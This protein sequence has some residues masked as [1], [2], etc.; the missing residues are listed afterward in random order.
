M[1][2]FWEREARL[3]A[4]LEDHAGAERFFARAESWLPDHAGYV[5]N[6]ATAIMR[7]KTRMDPGR[8]DAEAIALLERAQ[9]MN[10]LS[11]RI[12][13][14]Q[15]N[16]YR[17]SAH[18][19]LAVEKISEAIELY[20]YDAGYRMDRAACYLN[21]RNWQKAEADLEFIEREKL[22]V[23]EFQRRDLNM[24][25]DRLQLWR[26]HPE[27]AAQYGSHMWSKYEPA[28]NAP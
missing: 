20:P 24:L 11:P 2:E 4:G 28:S 22:P 15:S 13:Q 1:G 7:L 14:A 5:A 21:I 12:R 8:R 25:T 10:P 17:W 26:S 23:W 3:S 9:R 18:W 19:D 27:R 16:A 6:R